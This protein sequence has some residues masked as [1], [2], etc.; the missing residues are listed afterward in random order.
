M[1]NITKKPGLFLALAFIVFIIILKLGFWSYVISSVSGH[2]KSTDKI[3]GTINDL[4]VSFRKLPDDDSRSLM[5][6]AVEVSYVYN[7]NGY[8][9]TYYTDDERILSYHNGDEICI[10]V[11]TSEPSNSRLYRYGL[12]THTDAWKDVVAVA[13]GVG[14]VAVTGSFIRL[15]VIKND[16]DDTVIDEDNTNENAIERKYFKHYRNKD[17]YEYDMY[18]QLTD[19]DIEEYAETGGSRKKGGFKN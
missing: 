9:K 1:K 2:E 16:P 5:K 13:M 19:K 7:G 17:D 15:S 6:Y 14:C 11:D 10:V 4:Y 18:V 8:T 3:Y 12:N